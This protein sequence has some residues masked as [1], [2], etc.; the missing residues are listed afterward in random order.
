MTFWCS[1]CL[2]LSVIDIRCFRTCKFFGGQFPI[3]LTSISGSRVS[4]SGLRPWHF[5]RGTGVYTPT[6][7]LAL[8]RSTLKALE[9]FFRHKEQSTVTFIRKTHTLPAR[10]LIT[11]FDAH[12]ANAECPLKENLCLCTCSFHCERRESGKKKTANNVWVFSRNA[13][14]SMR[15][16]NK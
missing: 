10:L 4:V 16:V 13:S 5:R 9:I 1:C 12:A 7:S 15:I 3:F 2:H 8:D 6:I 11:K 14:I